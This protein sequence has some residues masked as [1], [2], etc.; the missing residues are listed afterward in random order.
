ME[1]HIADAPKHNFIPIRRE[2]FLPSPGRRKLR[3]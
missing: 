2:W 3:L 1:S